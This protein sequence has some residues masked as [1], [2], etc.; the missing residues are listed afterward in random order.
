MITPDELQAADILLSTGDAA[1]SWVIRGATVS[2]FSHAALYVGDGDIVE[3]IA[4]GV[5]RQSLEKAMGDDTLVVA[6]RRIGISA[7]QA[8]QVVRYVMEA[9]NAGKKYDALGAVGAGVT[10]PSGFAIG[11]FVSPIVTIGAVHADLANRLDPEAKFFCSELVALAF[12]KAGVPLGRGSAAST[13][14]ADIER[15]HVL[16]LIGELKS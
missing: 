15:S 1:V 10:S 7:A 5:V 16:N 6:Y 12:E 4:E 9:K 14:P 11:M 8:R 2:R 3:A 13:S